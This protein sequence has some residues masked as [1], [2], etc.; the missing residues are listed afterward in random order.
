M[1][2]DSALPLNTEELLPELSS[3]LPPPPHPAKTKERIASSVKPVLFIRNL[4][5]VWV[6]DR[7]VQM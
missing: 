1:A 2:I 4:A 6:K 5:I 7:T 3:P